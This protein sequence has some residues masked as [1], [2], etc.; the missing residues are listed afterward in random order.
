M[1]SDTKLLFHL[2][3]MFGSTWDNRRKRTGFRVG[4]YVHSKHSNEKVQ[5][6]MDKQ[7]DQKYME[8][9]ENLN[10]FHSSLL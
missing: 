5:G 4:R 7:K 1:F 10:P 8:Y 3:S 9:S 2:Q 6:W